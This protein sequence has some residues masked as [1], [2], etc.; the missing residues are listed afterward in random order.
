[1]NVTWGDAIRARGSVYTDTVVYPTDPK[2]P[3][4]TWFRAVG[5]PDPAVLANEKPGYYA[6]DEL[7]PA[8]Y[9]AQT[10]ASMHALAKATT[11]PALI[12]VE[13]T[14]TDAAKDCL[15]GIKDAQNPHVRIAHEFYVFGEDRDMDA[16]TLAYDWYATH[17]LLRRLVPLYN[18]ANRRDLGKGYGAYSSNPGFVVYAWTTLLRRFK[19][20]GLYDAGCWGTTYP[21]LDEVFNQRGRA[22]V[23]W[24]QTVAAVF[25]G[26]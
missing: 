16:A 17:G 3:G 20:F 25:N 19:A 22:V 8:Q 26:G 6:Y 7:L 18:V 12:A 1:M 15:L 11:G 4:A 9:P 10:R 13:W 14:L 5:H 24:D 21:A 2:W 23:A